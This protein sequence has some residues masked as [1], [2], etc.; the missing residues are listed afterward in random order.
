MQV[1]R[2]YHRIIYTF[3]HNYLPFLLLFHIFNSDLFIFTLCISL[4]K[5]VMW[6]LCA[7]CLTTDYLNLMFNS[8]HTD[9]KTF[10]IMIT[11][12]TYLLRCKFQTVVYFKQ[13]CISIKKPLRFFSSSYKSMNVSL[14]SHVCLGIFFFFLQA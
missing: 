2:F 5:K 1:Q 9:Q 4:S 8:L 3:T 12:L 13:D 10:L 14:L 11:I 7:V 6:Y